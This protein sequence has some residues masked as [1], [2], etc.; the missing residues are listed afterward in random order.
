[1]VRGNMRERRNFSARVYF[2]IEIKMQMILIM[3]R[4]T[5]PQLAS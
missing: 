3:M 5:M 2:P 1:M 4:M